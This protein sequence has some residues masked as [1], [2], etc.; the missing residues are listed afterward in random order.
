MILCITTPHNRDVHGIKPKEI[1]AL[2]VNFKVRLRRITVAPPLARRVPEQLLPIFYLRLA[3]IK[4][5]CTHYL[6]LFVE[7]GPQH[8]QRIAVRDKHS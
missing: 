8:A 5:L 3:C 6:G 7:E 1:K 4:P 2:F